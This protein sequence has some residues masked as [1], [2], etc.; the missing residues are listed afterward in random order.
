MS[1]TGSTAI[2]R[3]LTGSVFVPAPGSASTAGLVLAAV[4]VATEGAGTGV[5]LG[6][7]AANPVGAVLAGGAG[8]G[9][10]CVAGKS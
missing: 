7:D 10:A 9:I 3:L 2:G 5:V 1:Y 8:E 6:S 4:G